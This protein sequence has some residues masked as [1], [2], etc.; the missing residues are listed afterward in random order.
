[1]S[2]FAVRDD[3]LFCTGVSNFCGSAQRTFNLMWMLEMFL[4]SFVKRANIPEENIALVI[5]K[6]EGDKEK[7]NPYLSRLLELY[8]KIKWR[9]APNF[10][11]QWYCWDLEKKRKV[12]YEALNK[13]YT[14][15]FVHDAGWHKDYGMCMLIDADTF[16]FK[17]VNFDA[18]PQDKTTLA[19]VEYIYPDKFLTELNN[20]PEKDPWGNDFKGIHL[21]NLMR[22]VHVPEENIR[23]LQRGSHHLFINPKDMTHELLSAFGYY[24]AAIKVL[25]GVQGNIGCWCPEMGCYTLALATYGIDHEITHQREASF[26]AVREDEQCPEGSMVHYGFKQVFAGNDW[27]GK[28]KYNVE[29]PFDEKHLDYA[30]ERMVEGKFDEERTFFRYVTEVAEEYTI[31]RDFEEFERH[32]NENNPPLKESGY[33]Y[34]WETP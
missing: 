25:A 15:G 20:P 29:T 26:G 24:S 9:E 31:E 18:L 33:N 30:R 3:F 27:W 1:M 4:F 19:A 34:T 7:M 10:S 22:S 11:T 32:W 12:R 23:K 2:K 8:P 14:M 5:F 13:A 28:D 6:K 21:E 17:G 16:A